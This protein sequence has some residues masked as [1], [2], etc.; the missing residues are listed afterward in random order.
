MKDLFDS[1]KY[2]EFGVLETILSNSN[3]VNN[4]LEFEN[5]KKFFEER[6]S[7]LDYLS[8]LDSY[9]YGLVLLPPENINDLKI[10]INN[11][12]NY[13][14][15][16][17]ISSDCLYIVKSKLISEI[18]KL[19]YNNSRINEKVLDLCQD[20]LSKIKLSVWENKELLEHKLKNMINHEFIIDYLI[21]YYNVYKNK[22]YIKELFCTYEVLHSMNEKFDFL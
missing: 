5:N 21:N 14:Y 17:L 9:L 15:I 4:L 1:T 7:F 18:S 3:M 13:L 22:E 20:I 8:N 16:P 2:I 12:I 6:Y 10:W 11:Y 19:S